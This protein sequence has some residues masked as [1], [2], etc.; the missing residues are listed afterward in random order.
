VA[1]KFQGSLVG[2]EDSQHWVA[3]NKDTIFGTLPIAIAKAFQDAGEKLPEVFTAP[4]GA[5][6]HD[7]VPPAT[8]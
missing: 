6:P 7:T 5:H 3:S 4:Q 2:L 8:E 1:P